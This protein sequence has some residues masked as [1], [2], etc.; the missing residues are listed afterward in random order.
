M[1]E[2]ENQIDE[3]SSDDEDVEVLFGEI[4]LMADKKVVDSKPST[5]GSTGE[6]AEV[7]SNPDADLLASSSRCNLNLLI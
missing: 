2:E 6:D 4:C 5:S 1:V 7:I 3:N